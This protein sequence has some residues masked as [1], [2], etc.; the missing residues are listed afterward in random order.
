MNDWKSIIDF[1]AAKAKK[2]NLSTYKLGEMVGMAQNNIWRVLDKQH[3]P[4]LPTLMRI[5]DALEVDIVAVNRMDN[6]EPSEEIIKP[7]FL[8]SV[9][10]EA[11]ELYILHRPWPSCLIQIV[12]EIPVRFVVQDLYD[13]IEN[14][15][16]ILNMPFVEE[17]K[18]FYRRTATNSLDHN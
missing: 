15:A 2:L 3:A 14:P 7:K 16:D 10:Q 17:A 18:E 13:D 4:G 6:L 1:L 9:D 8:L 12:Q 11:G 5:A